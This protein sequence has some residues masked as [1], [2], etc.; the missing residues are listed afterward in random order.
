[1]LLQYLTHRYLQYALTPMKIVI[2]TELFLIV[3][4][5]RKEDDFDGINRGDALKKGV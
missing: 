3:M 4:E 5:Q 2:V 1:M